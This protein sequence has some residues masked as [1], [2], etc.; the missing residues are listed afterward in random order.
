MRAFRPPI[1]LFTRWQPPS[2][3]DVT[4]DFRDYIFLQH[5]FFFTGRVHREKMHSL[6]SR[7]DVVSYHFSAIFCRPMR[8]TLMSRL[9]S[10]SH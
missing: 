1:T 5:L 10:L 6:L 7:Y 8:V 4:D 3:S 2:K 9:Y